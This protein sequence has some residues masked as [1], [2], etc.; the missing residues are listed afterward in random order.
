MEILTRARKLG[1]SIIITLPKEIVKEES[2]HEGELVKIKVSKFKKSGFGISKGLGRFTEED[3]LKGQ[4][5][6]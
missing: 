6:E 5:E 2:I 3:E 1:G 4:L